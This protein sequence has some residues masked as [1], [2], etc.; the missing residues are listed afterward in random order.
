ML[1]FTGHFIT[2][3]ICLS[4]LRYR[5]QIILCASNEVLRIGLWKRPG[6]TYVLISPTAAPE[7]TGAETALSRQRSCE[8]CYGNLTSSTYFIGL[9]LTRRQHR[10]R[11][12]PMLARP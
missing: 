8:M 12:E 9:P 5:V 6:D 4:Y 10:S 3:I 2:L 1:C 11:P 7:T